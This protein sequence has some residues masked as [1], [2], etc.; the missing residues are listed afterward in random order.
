MKDF[1][2]ILNLK[3]SILIALNLIKKGFDRTLNVLFF[4]IKLCAIIYAID[5][6][7]S[8]VF[9]A[10]SAGKLFNIGI[11]AFTPLAILLTFSSLM[12]NRTRTIASKSHQFRS[13]Y[14]AERLLSA[15]ISYFLT[16]VGM[17][18]CYLIAD[19]YNFVFNMDGALRHNY[20]SLLLL[21]PIMFFI[22][23][24]FDLNFAISATKFEVSGKQTKFFARKVKKLL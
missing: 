19:K 16:L 23:F 24:C 6:F 10:V 20:H 2:I 4:L 21:I 17:V 18:F 5:I 8:F 14:I 11:A 12:Y 1:Q 9:E 13:L 15:T 22:L 7:A 3:N